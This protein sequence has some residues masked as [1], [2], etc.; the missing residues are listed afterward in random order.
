MP[1]ARVQARLGIRLL[2]QL[3]PGVVQT[4]VTLT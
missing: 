4:K 3:S 2:R 1:N